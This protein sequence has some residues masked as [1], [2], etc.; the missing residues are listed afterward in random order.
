[1]PNKALEPDQ[2]LLSAF[3][4]RKSHA[5]THWP[6]K[7]GVRPPNARRKNYGR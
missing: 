6:L 2:S 1:M 5:N 7:S 3:C 4:L